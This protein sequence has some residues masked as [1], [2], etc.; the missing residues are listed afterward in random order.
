MDEVAEKLFNDAALICFQCSR[1]EGGESQSPEC[2]SDCGALVVIKCAENIIKA[3]EERDRAF[4][5]A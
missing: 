2:P 3:I 1:R 5:A 4:E